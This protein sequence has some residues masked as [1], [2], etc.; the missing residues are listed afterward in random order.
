MP[1]QDRQSVGFSGATGRHR[2]H[3]FHARGVSREMTQRVGVQLANPPAEENA[4]PG[5]RIIQSR[6]GAGNPECYR[7]HSSLVIIVR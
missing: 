6:C 3:A 4:T 7:K 2:A 5:G 1:G